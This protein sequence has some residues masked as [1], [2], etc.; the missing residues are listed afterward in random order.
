[1]GIIPRGEGHLQP[2][3]NYE[4]ISLAKVGGTPLAIQKKLDGSFLFL[5]PLTPLD[6]D[7]QYEVIIPEDALTGITFIKYAL[8]EEEKITDQSLVFT[9]LSQVK[10][11]YLVGYDLPFNEEKAIPLRLNFKSVFP[12]TKITGVA[13]DSEKGF[14]NGSLF[15]IEDNGD[16]VKYPQQS[17]ANV[18]EAVFDFNRC[19][20]ELL[21]GV[22]NAY[23]QN[24][25]ADV[26]IVNEKGKQT[27]RLPVKVK[28][29]AFY[30]VTMMEKGYGLYDSIN[31]KVTRTEPVLLGHVELSKETPVKVLQPETITM[32]CGARTLF[33]F[34]D[35]TAGVVAGDTD[36]LKDAITLQPG[37]IKVEHM[38]S[39]LLGAES[40]WGVQVDAFGKKIEGELRDKTLDFVIKKPRLAGPLGF[41]L[42]IFTDTEMAGGARTITI[43][44]STVGFSVYPDGGMSILNFEGTPEIVVEGSGNITI[45]AGK[46]ISK[47]AGNVYDPAF[48][49]IDPASRPYVLLEQMDRDLAS[50]DEQSVTYV[51][52]NGV[53]IESFSTQWREREKLEALYQE[54]LKNKYGQEMGALKG[55]KLYDGKGFFS[56]KGRAA[57][58]YV[59]SVPEIHINYA[60]VNTTVESVAR[61]LAH[62][63]GHHYTIYNMQVKENVFLGQSDWRTTP[64][65]YA[66]NITN[67]P[68][69]RNDYEG[70]HAWCI[71]ELAAEDYVQ[72]LGSKASN[73][74]SGPV[75]ENPSFPIATEVPGLE[76]YMRELGGLAPQTMQALPKPSL[77]VQN[78]KKL[79]QSD[80]PQIEFTWNSVKIDCPATYMLALHKKDY[81][82]PNWALYT[83]EDESSPL[84]TIYGAENGTH[85]FVLYAQ[86]EKRNIVASNYVT[87]TIEE[88]PGT[89]VVDV[90]VED[91]KGI[92]TYT[93]DFSVKDVPVDSVR[94]NHVHLTLVN[95]ASET[96]IATISP[97]DAPNRTVTWS[98]SDKT[99]ATVNAT[100]VVTARGEGTATISVLTE[101]NY[102]TASCI[103]TV[104]P[105]PYMDWPETPAG[106]ALDKDWTISF[107]KPV[108]PASI[109]GNI[110]ITL[111]PEGTQQLD[112][113]SVQLSPVDGTK[114]LLNPDRQ[115]IYQPGTTYYLIIK[116]NIMSQTGNQFLKEGIRMMF[117]T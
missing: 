86:D 19:H 53:T 9:T 115:H 13:L 75:Q 17:Y 99:V 21:N 49:D 22:P 79:T 117:S 28:A 108:H 52:A 73:K 78:V 23:Y 37:K 59:S 76:Q 93:L 87:A 91:A 48:K 116:P 85:V 90:K 4:N 7:T 32:P 81:Y 58:F 2:G 27:I 109:D 105:K 31:E 43:L 88:K 107:S 51:G 50:L 92:T 114:V 71:E 3:P 95:G 100:G 18:T 6:Y 45:P 11:S 38:A 65:A 56:E 77:S 80:R 89:R 60:D 36:V 94:L 14:V 96:L 16:V 74:F 40:T 82:Y 69:I 98:S 61:T 110:I 41:I 67:N 83:L 26:D 8:G 12:N 24:L 30:T 44:R 70:G 72:L 55:V 103:V 97:A 113:V 64:Y 33:K 106:V 1:I 34:I 84:K 29:D 47:D 20:P 112:N 101:D 15:F 63:Y 68:N 46:E 35:G 42:D 5:T 111:D 66:R 10:A 62:E 57:G 25:T 102:K 104:I 54:L 39:E